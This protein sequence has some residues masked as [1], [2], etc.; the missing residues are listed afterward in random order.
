MVGR[1]ISYW[2]S[3]F[4]GGMLVFG[5]CNVK[6]SI[7]SFHRLHVT[8]NIFLPMEKDH[9]VLLLGVVVVVVVVV[10]PQYPSS[11]SSPPKKIMCWPNIQTRWVWTHQIASPKWHPCRGTCT[12][13]KFMAPYHR[14]PAV[15]PVPIWWRNQVLQLGLF[16]LR[17]AGGEGVD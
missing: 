13:S 11:A 6:L 8:K 2:N 4:L 5:G 3:P 16:N 14:R 17:R 15:S 7:F 1:C 9:F 12:S 10:L